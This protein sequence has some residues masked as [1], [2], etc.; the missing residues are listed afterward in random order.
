MIS[1]IVPVYNTPSA[2]LQRCIDSILCQSHGDF[3]LLLID[4][5]STAADTA[6]TLCAVHDPRV[7]CIRQE[8]GGVSAA[9]NTALD[10]AQGTYLQFLDSDDWLTPDATE[11][12]AEAARADT[13]AYLFWFTFTLWCHFLQILVGANIRP[14]R[15][16]FANAP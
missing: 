7:R 6:V 13:R 4:D 12:L 14:L 1:V 15:H 16:M 5:G 11:S 3:E 9:R 8:N 10:L 2:L